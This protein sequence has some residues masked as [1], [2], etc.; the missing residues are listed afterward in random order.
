MGFK[1]QD[2]DA[3]AAEH[4]P[5]ETVVSWVTTSADMPGGGAFRAGDGPLVHYSG[6][7]GGIRR[8]AAVAKELG[9]DPDK[10]FRGYG[11][12][13]LLLTDT[14][15][16]LGTRSGV[17]NRPKDLLHTAPLAGVRV[18]WF[19]HDAGSGNRFRHFITDFGDGR[20]RTEHTGLTALKRPVSS[21]A[22]AFLAALGDLAVEVPDP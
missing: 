2:L 10:G 4:L 21:N 17:R 8:R 20:W 16:S 12:T 11:G 22:D 13:F 3:W 5:G 14:S 19:D 18:H 15:L 9:Y 1:H 6:P 7:T